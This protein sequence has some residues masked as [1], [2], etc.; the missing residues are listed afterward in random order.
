VNVEADGLA[1]VGN[2]LRKGA[3]FIPSIAAKAIGEAFDVRSEAWVRD[4]FGTSGQPRVRPAFA[5]TVIE[6]I[7]ERRL[8]RCGSKKKYNGQL[9][10][11]FIIRTALN[12]ASVRTQ[13]AGQN[14]WR[15]RELRL[16]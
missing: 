12:A 15:F 5:T 11:H 8:Q 16:I 7:R 1:E 14:I 4:D 3:R 2:S 10:F 13:A 9:A 6:Q